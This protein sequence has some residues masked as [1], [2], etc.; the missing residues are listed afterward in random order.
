MSHTDT[1]PV[2]VSQG[3]ESMRASS[4][5]CYSA[6]AEIIDNSIQAEATYVDIVFNNKKSSPRSIDSVVF[7]DDG[8]GMDESVLKKCLA[9]GESTRPNDR[10]GIG[11]FGVGMTLG[12][13]H[14]CR[15]IEVYSKVSGAPWLY[16]YLDLD[17]V[18][19]GRGI[20]HPVQKSPEAAWSKRIPKNHGTLIKWS[21]YDANH[22]SLETKLIPEAKFYFGR[23]FRKYMWGK[24]EGYP[25]LDIFVNNSAV[26]AWDPLFYTKEKTEFPDDEK[27]TLLAPSSF[28]YD[29]PSDSGL[30]GKS[31]VDINMSVLPD[32]LIQDR[33]DRDKTTIGKTRKLSENA[34]ISILRNGREVYFGKLHYSSLHPEKDFPIQSYVGVEISFSA[35]LDKEFTVRNIKSGAQ[36]GSG[37]R[38]EIERLARATLVRKVEDIRRLWDKREAEAKKEIQK[39]QQ[40][41]S[42]TNDHVDSTTIAKAAKAK[43]TPQQQQSPID[44]AVEIIKPK[45]T[46]EEAEMIAKVLKENHVT[47]QEHRFPGNPIAF[48]DVE[49]G[50][51]CKILVFNTGSQFYQKYKMVLDVLQGQN[52]ELARNYRVLIDVIFMAY[53]LAEGSLDYD[54]EQKQGDTARRIQGEWAINMNHLM[55]SWNFD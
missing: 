34:G 27:A 30:S 25:A 5:D 12:A 54:A 13:I 22:P 20:P 39:E 37:I 15:R 17:E 45:A 4:F 55:E 43:T 49:H 14:E 23:V 7:T 36:P 29:I 6:Y 44:V 16:T 38:A 35:E 8:H 3:L 48:I 32:S 21:K 33:R 40:A 41:A 47:I 52:P 11:R 51:D 46:S 26:F 28:K 19:T 18:K 9:L 53:A 1:S 2:N 31:Q 42:I 24:I 50:E 10:K